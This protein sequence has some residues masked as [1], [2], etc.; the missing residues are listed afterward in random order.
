M[1][2]LFTPQEIEELR[3]QLPPRY[4]ELI[5]EK[6]KVSVPTIARFF[7]GSKIRE[8]N[9][10]IIYDAALEL[11]EEHQHKIACRKKKLKALMTNKQ[12]QNI[13]FSS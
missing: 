10:E 13:N 3:S 7:A 9:A 6:T 5:S 11:I 1:E 2:E 12:Q 4:R 8:N